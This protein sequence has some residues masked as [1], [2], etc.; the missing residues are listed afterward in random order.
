MVVDAPALISCQGAAP[1]TF[2]AYSFA[3]D[4][5]YGTVDG[6]PQ[7]AWLLNPTT[8]MIFLAP[9]NNQSSWS[10]SATLRPS[11]EADPAWLGTWIEVTGH[12][13]DPEALTCRQDVTADSIEWWLGR[14]WLIDQCRTTFVVSDVKIVSGP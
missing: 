3:C 10:T 2:R 14:Y 11:L 9:G 13:D 7:P 6:N 8:N 5:C 4:Q 1:F 12:Y